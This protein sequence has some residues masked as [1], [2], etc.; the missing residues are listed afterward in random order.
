L[1]DAW[2]HRLT[3]LYEQ[4]HEMERHAWRS[5]TKRLSRSAKPP[6]PAKLAFSNLS[7]RYQWYAV[8]LCNF[9]ELIGCIGWE[10][11]Q[12]E[13]PQAYVK[14]V[15][16]DVLQY[17]SLIAAHSARVRKG[18]SNAAERFASLLPPS[19]LMNGRYYAGAWLI[20]GT[21][22]GNPVDSQRLREWSLTLAHETLAARY[23]PFANPANPNQPS[24]AVA[25]SS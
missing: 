23:R 11:K 24:T 22:N 14:R 3:F 5:L 21:D 2:H 15:F 10:S 9:V 16:P 20:A 25:E 8:T 1:L 17:R 7:C 6:Q 13:R 4:M 18:K 12:H 19:G